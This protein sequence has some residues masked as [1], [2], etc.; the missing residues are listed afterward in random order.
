MS[1]RILGPFN[2]VEGDLEVKIDVQKGAV[3]NAWVTSPMYRGF[4][5]ILHGKYPQD[6]LIYTPR[7]CGICSVSQSVASAAALAKVAQ[8]EAPRN[9]ELAINLIHATENIADHFTHFY[10]FFMPDFARVG[11]ADQPWHGDVVK[12]FKAIKGVAAKDVMKARAQ[13]MHIMGILAGKW[14]HTLGI[15]PGGCSKTVE[16]QEKMR[17]L[18]VIDEFRDYLEQTLFGVALEQILEIET[19]DQLKAWAEGQNPSLNDFARFLQLADELELEQL[20]LSQKN[21]MSYGVYPLEGENYFKEGVWRNGQL[22]SLDVNA[23]TEDISHSWM[24]G[25][26]EPHHP[27]QGVT[28]PDADAESGYSWCKAPRLSGEVVEVG[29]LPRQLIDGQPLINQLVNQSG[30]NV[31]NRVIARL[32]EIPRLV[33]ALEDWAKALKPKQPFCNQNPFPKEAE[34]YGLTEAARGSLGHWIRVKNGRILNY[35]II[36][37]TTWNFSPRDAEGVQGPLEQALMDTVVDE[38]DKEPVA[39]QHIVRSFDPCMVCTVH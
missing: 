21:F 11:Y 3:K 37:P 31:R 32:I 7:I 24:G 5:Q 38:N 16:V 13:L 35:Q 12:R 10:L 14:P 33:L 36:A 4:E 28:L 1:K 39:I 29:A 22:E 30:S 6:A 17:L 34:G 26:A 9:G 18:A 2:R 15:Q 27:Y 19:D 25:Q 20:G 8:V 23:I